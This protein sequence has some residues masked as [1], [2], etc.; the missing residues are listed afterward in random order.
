MS[1]ADDIIKKIEAGIQDLTVLKIQTLMGKLEVDDKKNIDFVPNQVIDGIISKIDLVDGDIKTQITEEFYQKYP[2]LVQF[3][4]SRETKGHE[5]IEGN[6]LALSTIVK[7]LKE[8][9][10]P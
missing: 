2:E 9:F 10:K 8:L 6:I 1:T 4:Q 5:I 7:T 3:H